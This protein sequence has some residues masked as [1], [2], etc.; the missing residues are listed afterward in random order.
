MITSTREL[1][2]FRVYILVSELSS[3]VE[4]YSD[5]DCTTPFLS[6]VYI[7]DNASAKTLVLP[8]M[9]FTSKSN[10]D[11]ASSHQACLGERFFCVKKCCNNL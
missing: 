7:R 4:T 6:S 11:R 10:S 1:T 5:S 8:G 3:I 2:S 9:Y